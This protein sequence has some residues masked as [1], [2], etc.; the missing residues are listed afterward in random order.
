MLP[1]KG[2]CK[3]NVLTKR[4]SLDNVVTYEH[5][6]D[7]K[8]DLANIPK[9]EITLGTIAIVLKDD[10]ESIGIYIADSN[11][12][13]N[14]FS[15]GS[16]TEEI[17]LEELTITENGTYLA[18][19]G[20]GYNKVV[21]DIDFPR[22]ME[23]GLVTRTLSV[24][25]NPTVE[26]IGQHAF[27]TCAS[28]TTVSFPECL[29]IGDYAFVGCHSLATVS[30]PECTYIGLNAFSGDFVLSNVSF[31]KCTTIRDEA[32]L[33]CRSL[34][35]VS[36]PECVSIYSSAFAGCVALTNVTF[37]KCTTIHNNAFSGC[38]SLTTVSFPECTS[39]G[40]SAFY[41]CWNLSEV[42]LNKSIMTT[43]TS[44]ASIVFYH[45]GSDYSNIL[46]YVPAS[47]ISDYQS[48]SKWSAVS[49]R[50][51]AYDFSD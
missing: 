27:A 16:S 6:C 49:S 26:G 47:L 1:Y 28:L 11:K 36:F 44:S 45:N 39:I 24:Y 51:S 50:F 40:R 8:A 37:P 33:Y 23:N 7:T 15:S 34:A 2:G 29:Y 12:E 9:N 30:F 43:L 3:M 18:D 25:E 46:F 17:E 20:K 21:A 38:Y 5:F 10:D 48:D 4:G 14:G 42:Y 19:E 32:F 41:S 35:T 22:D 13:W 31:P